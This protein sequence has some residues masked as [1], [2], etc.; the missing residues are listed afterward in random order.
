MKIIFVCTGNTCRS[1]LAESYAKTQFRNAGTAFESR[2]LMV[3]ADGI[4]PLSKRIIEREGLE[5][6]SLPRQL[7]GE[8]TEEALLLVMTKAHKR[9]VKDQFPSSDVCMISEFSEGTVEDV[10]DPYGGSEA[11]Y[12]RAFRQLKQFIDKFRL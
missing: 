5:E 11:D 1:P 3:F 4:N 6:P 8:D 9:A 12:E 2:G 7:M 10:I